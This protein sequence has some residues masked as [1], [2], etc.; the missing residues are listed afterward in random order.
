M[1]PAE[2]L[3]ESSA[4]QLSDS[5]ASSSG[6]VVTPPTARVEEQ[7]SAGSPVVESP[8]AAVVSPLPVVE[9]RP[10]AAT[11]RPA[12]ELGGVVAPPAVEVAVQPA[13]EVAA[14]PAPGA[15]PVSGAQPVPLSNGQLPSPPPAGSPVE[16]PRADSVVPPAPTVEPQP[17]V[18][19]TQ[20]APAPPNSPDGPA[21][22]HAPASA[23]PAQPE[24]GGQALPAPV[25]APAPVPSAVPSSAPVAPPG[26]GLA[27]RPDELPTTQLSSSPE[28]QPVAPVGPVQVTVP[29]LQSPEPSGD[30][31]TV[32]VLGG[33]SPA[34]P[35]AVERGSL[36]PLAPPL[37]P[38]AG[39]PDGVLRPPVVEARGE[40]P[41]SV[42]VPP[43]PAPPMTAPPSND[44]LVTAPF[45]PPRQHG[46][47][48][49]GLRRR[50]RGRLRE[51]GHGVGRAAGVARAAEPAVCSL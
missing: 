12:V 51:P 18:P 50:V 25:V 37:T 4:V 6:N 24:S 13:A 29:V 45:T 26:P 20:P 7:P 49:E 48:R 47:R 23:T 8:G 31:L 2:S 36:L 14:P 21:G 22:S 41:R 44:A 1:R 28:A 17:V 33:S 3:A 32:P 15:Q 35:P 9:A 10:A 19:P 16:A 38:V 43:A 40:L 11:D 27:S 34:P 42:E 30:G 5:L 39:K 46:G